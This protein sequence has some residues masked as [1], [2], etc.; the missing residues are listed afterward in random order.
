MKRILITGAAGG[1]GSVLRAGLRNAYP[2]IRLSDK[3][4]LS[5]PSSGE[6][7]VVA[8]LGDFDA[9]RSIVD[10]MDCVVHLGG[11]PREGDWAA[12][13]EANIVGTRNMFE[14]ARLGGIKRVVFASSNHV[15]GYYRSSR[16]V[17]IDELPRPD[18]RYGVSKVFGE[19]IGQLYADKHGMSVA[20]LRIGS[21]REKPEDARQLSTWISPRDM[22]Q[23][24]RCA[25]DAPDYNFLVLYGVSNNTRGRWLNPAAKFINYRP[26]DNAE[27]YAEQFVAPIADGTDPAVEFQGGSFCA[28]EFSN[29]IAKIQ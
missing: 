28:M 8:D 2:L 17:G 22:V 6:E 13:L 3:R 20:A 9:I 29:K 19:A 11:V 16:K 1:I 12:I 27:M 24:V 14:A 15:I 23:L 21:F 26:K 18:S 4:P 10:G 7:C 5:E 25:I